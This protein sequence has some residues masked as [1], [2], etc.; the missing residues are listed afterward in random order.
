MF[1]PHFHLLSREASLVDRSIATGLSQL[2][3]VTR[4]DTGLFFSAL[5]ALSIGLERLMKLTLIVERRL[6]EPSN[7]MSDGDLRDLGHNL[8]SLHASAR[9]ASLR[10]QSEIPALASLPLVQQELFDLIN[11]FGMRTRYFNLSS[12]VGAS[13]GQID[14][15]VEYGEILFKLFESDLSAAQQQR[16][17]NEQ[18]TIGAMLDGI[19][20][21]IA[22]NF[23]GN[24]IGTQ[25]AIDLDVLLR[26]TASVSIAHIIE[27]IRPIVRLAQTL[28]HRAFYSSDPTAIWCP[29][30]SEFFVWVPATFTESKRKRR[31]P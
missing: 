8:A 26:F 5:F 9:E 18:Q 19:S 12:V 14:P 30:L 22:T 31:F 4:N 3:L 15:L 25:Q 6:A 28:G 27:A 7:P 24:L 23:Q 21:T 29:E 1:H 16:A 13:G 11:R 2:R 17:R 10:Q 20:H